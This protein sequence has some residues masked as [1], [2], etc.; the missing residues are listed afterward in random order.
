MIFFMCSFSILLVGVLLSIFAAM[1]M[2]E[3]V[4]P[5]LLTLCVVGVP[6]NYHIIYYL[7]QKTMTEL[8][9]R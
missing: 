1:F 2:R 6:I 4:T 9:T 5:F 3:I 8:Q 7:P